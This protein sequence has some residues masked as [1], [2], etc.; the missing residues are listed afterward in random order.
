MAKIIVDDH[1]KEVEDG[2]SI[3]PVCEELGVPFGCEEGL[4]GSCTVEVL[5]G[6]ENLSDRTENE[7]NLGVYDEHR[8]ACQCKIKQ[9]NVKLKF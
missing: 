6:A 7:E 8:L 5:E 2:A 9:G 3:I 1:E 4:C